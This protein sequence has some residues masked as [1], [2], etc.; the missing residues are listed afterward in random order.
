ME[1]FSPQTTMD[2]E[3][4]VRNN[5]PQCLFQCPEGFKLIPDTSSTIACRDDDGDGDGEWGAEFPDCIGTSLI[6]NQ[7]VN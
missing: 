1:I 5:L 7:L 4:S 6:I 2:C 3:I